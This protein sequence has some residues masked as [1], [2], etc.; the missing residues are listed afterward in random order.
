MTPNPSLT[1][2]PGHCDRRWSSVLPGRQPRPLCGRRLRGAGG[3]RGRNG[4]RASD[5]LPEEGRYQGFAALADHRSVLRPKPDNR[6]VPTGNLRLSRARSAR[7]RRALDGPGPPSEPAATRPPL[8][9]RPGAPAGGL[10]G[11]RS[12]PTGNERLPADASRASAAIPLPRESGRAQARSLG[13][14]WSGSSLRTGRLPL[15]DSVRLPPW[16]D[17]CKTTAAASPFQ[18]AETG[19]PAAAMPRLGSGQRNRWR[20]RLPPAE[21][22]TRAILPARGRGLLPL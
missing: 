12:P 14:R 6:S 7:P 10:T 11:E 4:F 1:E 9:R 8:G 3:V 21:R 2:A 16:E 5:E 15:P 20:G 17:A 22:P 18:A 19:G 13:V